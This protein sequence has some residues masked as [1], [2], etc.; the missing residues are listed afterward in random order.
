MATMI[1]NYRLERYVQPAVEI[2]DVQ[3]EKGFATSGGQGPS[4]W[5]FDD[6]PEFTPGF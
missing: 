6:L 3:V 2:I 1:N 5:G 4:N